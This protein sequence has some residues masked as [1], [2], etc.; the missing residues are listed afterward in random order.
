MR[1]LS[2]LKILLISK[3]FNCA[4]GDVSQAFQYFIHEGVVTGGGYRTYEGC[5]PYQI[6]AAGP[7]PASAKKCVQRCQ[8]GY[9]KQ[10]SDNKITIASQKIYSLK[11]KEVKQEII[12]NGPV[13]AE[14]DLYEDFLHYAG[15]FKM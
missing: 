12:A 15:N 11:N 6:P 7:F 14:F 1:K 2:L 3:F 9:G 10:Y 13:I 8:A 4:G 5:R